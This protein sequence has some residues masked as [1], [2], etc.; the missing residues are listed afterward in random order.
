MATISGHEQGDSMHVQQHL[1]NIQVSLV[2]HVL[3]C[4]VPSCRSAAWCSG[5]TVEL[6]D[7]HS[8]PV[9]LLQVIADALSSCSDSEAHQE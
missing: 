7:A 5:E 2:T 1:L 3:R 4:C 8:A 6:V 9:N